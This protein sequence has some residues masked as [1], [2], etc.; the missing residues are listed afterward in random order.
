MEVVRDTPRIAALLFK[1]AARAAIVDDARRAGMDLAAL[2]EERT[3][4]M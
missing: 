3:G 4:L 1:L 2:S